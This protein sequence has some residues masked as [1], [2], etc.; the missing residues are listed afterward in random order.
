MIIN[1]FFSNVGNQRFRPVPKFNQLFLG[2]RLICPP[3]SMDIY[4]YVFEISWEQEHNLLG[5]SKKKKK[6][7]LWFWVGRANIWVGNAQ[8]CPL[9]DCPL[10]VPA[11]I[12]LRLVCSVLLACTENDEHLD[13]G[14]DRFSLSWKGLIL[15]AELYIEKTCCCLIT[16]RL[17]ITFPMAGCNL[18][19]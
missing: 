8:T 4:R 5:V 13:Q 10:K 12:E 16:I 17:G 14:D 19:V 2:L 11:W 18:P 9:L 3:N 15:L 1:S 6:K 7:V